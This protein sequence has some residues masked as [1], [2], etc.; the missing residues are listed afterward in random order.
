MITTADSGTSVTG[1]SKDVAFSC[2]T[3]ENISS[4]PMDPGF[5]VGMH[6]IL[7]NGH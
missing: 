6:D 1:I 3:A 7:K 2:D 4:S 5:A